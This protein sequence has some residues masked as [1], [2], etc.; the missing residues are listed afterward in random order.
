MNRLLISLLPDFS[1]LVCRLPI[2]G[3]DFYSVFC[4]ERG[5]YVLNCCA[6]AILVVLACKGVALLG[7]VGHDELDKIGRQRGSCTGLLPPDR[8]HARV[9]A[10][11]GG[12]PAIPAAAHPGTPGAPVPLGVLIVHG[13]FL[14]L[15]G[16]GLGLSVL[17]VLGIRGLVANIEAV[18][19]GRVRIDVERLAARD[20]PY[21]MMGRQPA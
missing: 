7:T 14:L 12:I 1:F 15:V 3:R 6:A 10:P 4:A 16:Q 5:F 19:H 11:P 2:P 18:A 21:E 13:R 9:P 8:S 17:L 20:P